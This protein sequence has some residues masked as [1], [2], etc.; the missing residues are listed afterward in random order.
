MDNLLG[1]NKRMSPANRTRAAL[2]GAEVAASLVT[3]DMSTAKSGI[4]WR[5]LDKPSSKSG[6]MPAIQSADL[7]NSF[8]THVIGVGAAA[9]E[10][11]MPY[12][13]WLERGWVQLKDDKP[14]FH[15]RPFMK[16]GVDKHRRA[17]KAAMRAAMMGLA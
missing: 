8:E 10:A 17:I 2:R 11:N 6:E 15:I 4:W 9:W 5:N 7:V 14:V 12:A 3:L 1:H 13:F 16:P